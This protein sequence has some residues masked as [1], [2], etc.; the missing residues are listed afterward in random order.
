MTCVTLEPI[1]R[2][3]ERGKNDLPNGLTKE[4]DDLLHVPDFERLQTGDAVEIRI[5]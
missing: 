5:P 2:G 3:F 4:R 1:E